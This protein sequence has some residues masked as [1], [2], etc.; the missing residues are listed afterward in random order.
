MIWYIK[1]SIFL[2]NIVYLYFKYYYFLEFVLLI[3]ILLFII[4]AIKQKTIRP[5]TNTIAIIGYSI[6]I[7][8]ELGLYFVLYMCSDSVN[9]PTVIV[10]NHVV[11]KANVIERNFG[12][13]LV[14]LCFISIITILM[15]LVSII[16][17]IRKGGKLDSKNKRLLIIIGVLNIISCV[18][19]LMIILLLRN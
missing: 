18:L 14:I 6:F 2:A 8:I 19:G 5:K 3:G 10:G 7:T 11:P 4:D 15:T 16:K 12:I 9:N 17:C 1:N 13:V